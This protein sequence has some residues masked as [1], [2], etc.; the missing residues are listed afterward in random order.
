MKV[1]DFIEQLQALVENDPEVGELEVFQQSCFDDPY[2]FET[3]Y[4]YA[5]EVYETD[6]GQTYTDLAEVGDEEV[7]DTIP[8][9]I[10]DA[11]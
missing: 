8:A 9:L 4:M 6:G 2:A 5:S 11:H 10:I 1:K 3:T 7:T